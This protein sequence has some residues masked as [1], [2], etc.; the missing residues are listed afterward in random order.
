MS[1]DKKRTSKISSRDGASKIDANHMWESEK[2]VRADV[3]NGW[4]TNRFIA[5]LV[6]WY[7]SILV[8]A[9]YLISVESLVAIGLSAY[10]TVCELPKKA[11]F[12]FNADCL[13]HSV[14]FFLF[15]S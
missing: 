1:P 10:L 11:S 5:V 3:A 4:N 7:S 13:S 2:S 9:Y 12:N 15:H 14:F 8:F 6:D